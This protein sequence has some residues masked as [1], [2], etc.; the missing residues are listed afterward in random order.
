MCRSSSLGDA[1]AQDL[2]RGRAGK[3]RPP[4]SVLW[5][6]QQAPAPQSNAFKIASEP[7]SQE[8]WALF[9]ELLLCWALR[10]V[11]CMGAREEL[12]LSSPQPR[13]SWGCE[14]HWFSKLHVLGDCLSGAGLKC[15]VWTFPSSGRS[16]RF[17]VPFW[18]WFTSLWMWFITRLCPSLSYTFSVF[19]FP[20][21]DS[22]F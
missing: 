6:P 2:S 14:P 17:P 22:Y 18:L 13:G 3:C 20:L 21:F 9:K 19:F 5:V 8:I 15:G 7:L 10:W 12:L 1:G 4:T 11:S 16:S